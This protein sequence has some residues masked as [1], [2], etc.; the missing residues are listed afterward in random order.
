MTDWRRDV[1]RRQR[2]CRYLIE[3]WL[4]QEVIGSIDQNDLNRPI[5]QAF[6]RGQSAEPAA[7]DHN[8]R[9]FSLCHSLSSRLVW[10]DARVSIPQ[11]NQKDATRGDQTAGQERD[12]CEGL[13]RRIQNA[14]CR[15]RPTLVE[16][17]AAADRTVAAV[18]DRRYF[19]DSG[20]N[21][22]SQSAATVGF[23]R[24]SEAHHYFS[25]TKVKSS[26]HR[27]AIEL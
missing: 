8:P 19:V 7:H 12:P 22:R 18:Y 2:R 10:P 13:P 24:D 23:T 11:T 20:K 16:M 14:E 5:P 4:K 17:P 25:V 1:T 21:R 3:E 15:S 6:R 26:I 27:F 9:Q